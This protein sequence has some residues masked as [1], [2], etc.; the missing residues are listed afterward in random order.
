MPAQGLGAREGSGEQ[1][2]DN[3]N[4]FILFNV[5]L[6][7]LSLPQAHCIADCLRNHA[8]LAS[9]DPTRYFVSVLGDFNFRYEDKPIL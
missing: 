3:G 7:G 8:H 6:Y 9:F 5:H 2:E 4:V 1:V